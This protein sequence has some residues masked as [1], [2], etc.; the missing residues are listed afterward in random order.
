MKNGVF[1]MLRRMAL[2]STDVSDEHSASIIRVTESHRREN[3][4]PY[5]NTIY[6]QKSK[7]ITIIG[8]GGS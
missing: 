4:K 5:M 8:L 2:V 6:I 3:I 1:W 7:A